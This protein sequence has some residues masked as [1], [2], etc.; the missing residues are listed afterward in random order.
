VK[1]EESEEMVVWW[2]EF[3]DDVSFESGVKTVGVMDS[4]M[5]SGDHMEGKSKRRFVWRL[6]VRTSPRRR[7]GVNHTVLPANTPHL[8]SPRSV[9]QRAPLLRVVIAAI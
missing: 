4:E 8:P 7:S 5:N 3:V 2:E 9:H 1:A 6:I